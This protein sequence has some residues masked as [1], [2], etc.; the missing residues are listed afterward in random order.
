MILIFLFLVMTKETRVVKGVIVAGAGVEEMAGVDPAVI[1]EAMMKVTMIARAAIGGV[2]TSTTAATD[3][4]IAVIAVATVVVMTVVVVVVIVQE[5]GKNRH[6]LGRIL[7]PMS[8][9]GIQ[10]CQLSHRLRVL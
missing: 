4:I 1:V 6:Y 9:K 2:D 5:K 3:T 7:E 10:M 8:Q